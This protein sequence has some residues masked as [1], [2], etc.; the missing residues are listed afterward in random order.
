MSRFLVPH[1]VRRG[2][3]H[4]LGSSY[5]EGRSARRRPLLV[6]REPAR[7]R[8]ARL[9]RRD[10]DFHCSS[11][12]AEMGL[13]DL[14]R[15]RQAFLDVMKAR[16]PR[17]ARAVRRRA[18]KGRGRRLGRGLPRELDRGHSAA[19]SASDT[20]ACTTHGA[21]RLGRHLRP[22]PQLRHPRSDTAKRRELAPEPYAESFRRRLILPGE[23]TSR[24]DRAGPV[25]RHLWRRGA[26]A[27]S[28]TGRDHCAQES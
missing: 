18:P 14:A 26:L 2:K 5:T 11:S 21:V 16:L 7:L 17:R 6:P 27:A 12:S 28:S 9:R 13:V 22:S 3:K 19:S 4:P 24:A 8:G 25:R 20:R 15:P 23:P 10:V 1:P